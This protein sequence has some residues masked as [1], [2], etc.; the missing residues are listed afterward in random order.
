LAALDG[1]SLAEDPA[2]IEKHRKSLR[3][4]AI[5]AKAAQ[6][7]GQPVSSSSP[8]TTGGPSDAA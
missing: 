8:G 6:R 7:R 5:L 4:R 2:Q 1:G 3:A